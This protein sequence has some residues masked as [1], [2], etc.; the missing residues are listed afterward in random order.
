VSSVHPEHAD[1]MGTVMRT[2]EVIALHGRSATRHAIKSGRWQSPRRGVVTLHNGP[3]SPTECELVAL[4]S[5]APAAALSGPT[6]LAH[7]GHELIPVSGMHIVLPEGA[8]RPRHPDVVA[9]WSTKL[10]ER[11]IH[12][13]REPR[14]TRPARSLVDAASWCHSDRLARSYI[15]SGVQQ[16]LANMTTIMDAMTRRGPCRRRAL[17]IESVQ[18][19]VGGIQSLPERDF[20]EICR[21]HHIPQPSRQVKVTAPD[22]RYYLDAKWEQLGLAVE[23][24]GIPHLAVRRWDA[25]LFRANEIVIEGDRLL[26]FSSYAVRHEQ[27]AVGSQLQ[28]MFSHLARIAS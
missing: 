14:R 27:V 19:A 2:S 4:A 1:Q 26:I 15:I 6:S 22:G 5:C 24:H 16:G 23:I 20:G 25:D 10:D 8:Q 7:D 17:I 28:R 18:D 13:L 3:L 21:T 9:H 12:P 11:D